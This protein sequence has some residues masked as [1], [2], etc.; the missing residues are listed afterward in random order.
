MDKSAVEEDIEE[1]EKTI[2]C[3]CSDA[4]STDASCSLYETVDNLTDMCSELETEQSIKSEVDKGIQCDRSI[5][6]TSVFLGQNHD[7]TRSQA[8]IEKEILVF[9]PIKCDQSSNL[10]TPVARRQ[11]ENTMPVWKLHST[12]NPH[13]DSDDS[14]PKSQTKDSSEDKFH[15][16]SVDTTD[17]ISVIEI[18]DATLESDSVDCIEISDDTFEKTFEELLQEVTLLCDEHTAKTGETRDMFQQES[19]AENQISRIDLEQLLCSSP[20]VKAKDIVIDGRSSLSVSQ[21]SDPNFFSDAIVRSDLPE[22]SSPGRFKGVDK[23]QHVYDETLVDDLADASVDILGL[24]TFSFSDD[25]DDNLDDLD[26]TVINI[27]QSEKTLREAEVSERT[28]ESSESTASVC[29]KTVSDSGSTRSISADSTVPISHVK[30]FIIDK[31]IESEKLEVDNESKPLVIEGEITSASSLGLQQTSDEVKQSGQ[32]TSPAKTTVKKEDILIQ[33]SLVAE[34]QNLLEET[35]LMQLVK[36]KWKTSGIQRPD[37]NL[38]KCSRLHKTQKGCFNQGLLE[39][40]Q[41]IPPLIRTVNNYMYTQSDVDP[42]DLP[43]AKRRCIEGVNKCSVGQSTE[44]LLKSL[45]GQLDEINKEWE[46]KLN[47]LHQQEVEKESDLRYKHSVVVRS[48]HVR[49]QLELQSLKEQLIYNPFL[50]QF[51]I[52]QLH[53]EHTFQAHRLRDVHRN[54]MAGLRSEAFKRHATE[55]DRYL[56]LFNQLNGMI[57]TFE[58]KDVVNIISKEGSYVAVDLWKGPCRSNK[59]TKSLVKVCL[60]ADIASY[61][62][63]EDEIYDMFYTY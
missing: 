30:P 16:F 7:E 53:Q 61:I 15:V 47:F 51:R 14:T 11:H 37:I 29:E 27:L 3:I 28:T 34:R 10:L 6:D 54:E 40:E 19:A 36:D 48:L 50:L 45:K 56:R 59:Q 43:E 9:T 49:Q 38:T 5:S 26:T 25:E 31:E 52:L 46:K 24:D 41:R 2:L 13:D 57:K 62:M 33:S 60:P 17:S 55:Q 12:P 4:A 44:E 21:V 1:L 8:D 63:R 39:G 35:E 23:S 58:N 20:K 18:S 22:D 42:T 32:V